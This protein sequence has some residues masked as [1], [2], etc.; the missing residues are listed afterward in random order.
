MRVRITHRMSGVVGGVGLSRFEPGVTYEVDDRTGA[1]LVSMGSEV[2]HQS[3]SRT[4]GPR[5]VS[6]SHER[7]TGGIS[8]TPPSHADDREPPP[9]PSQKSKGKGQK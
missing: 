1:E 3:D 4:I 6:A 2:V 7:L 5:E 9:R 8:V